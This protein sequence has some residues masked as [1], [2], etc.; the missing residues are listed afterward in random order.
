MRLPG[1]LMVLVYLSLLSA[2]LQRT[3]VSILMATLAAA[4]MGWV[5]LR[6]QLFQPMQEIT[7]ELRIANRDLRQTL[8]DLSAERAKTESLTRQLEAAG[9]YRSSFLDHLGHRLRTP[10]NSI[11][12]Y[13]QLLESGLYG[14]LNERQME[15][16][17]TMQRNTDTLLRVIH[18]MLNLNAIAA[19]RLELQ[20]ATIELAPLIDKVF[21]EVRQRYPEKQP[22]LVRE[23]P[24]DLHP[25]YGDAP[26]IEQ[27]LT[28]LVDNAVKF[29]LGDA[30]DAGDAPADVR[31]VAKNVS[32]EGGKSADFPLP[33]LGWLADGDWVIVSVIDRGI[34]IAPEEQ[35]QIF[36]EFFQTGDKR[37]ADLAGTGLGLVITKRLVEQHGGSVWLKSMP[38]Q[39]STFFVALRSVRGEKG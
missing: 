4:W 18:N 5:V 20:F 1:L 9:E 39:G 2:D 8:T 7:D 36:D 35:S 38:D 14:D 23:L 33:L 11:T 31:V 3:P 30:G 6:T 21:G 27:I 24:A 16:L 17:R 26:S 28:Q 29:S 32:V 12:G 34:G 37:A 25:I 10:L 19:G 13:S 22:A 15:R